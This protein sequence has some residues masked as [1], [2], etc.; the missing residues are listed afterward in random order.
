[1]TSRVRSL[2]KPKLGIVAAPLMLGLL[3]A[4]PG[5]ARAQMPGAAPG[6]P[7]TP[8]PPAP[9]E[10]MP[11][12]GPAI[13]IRIALQTEVAFGVVKGYFRNHLVGARMDLR[14][15][16]RVSFGGY[17]GYANLKGKDGRAH[18]ALP[19]AQVEYL[20]GDPAAAV[21]FPL[22]FASGYVLGN[23]PMVRAA[24]GL[25]FALGTNID[26]IT[27]LVAPMVWLTN[28]Q[29]LLS[30]NLSLELAIRL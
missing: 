24:T 11:E 12:V 29:M 6:S 15:S 3:L 14:F 8:M 21:R 10:P 7:T 9:T 13:P 18:S 17:L 23:G 20:A 5:R 2:R 1:M 4:A 25:A 16:P 27:E 26:L 19:Y 30:L 28:D 22:R